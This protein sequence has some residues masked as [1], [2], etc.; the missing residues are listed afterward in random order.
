M[1]SKYETTMQEMLEAMDRCACSLVADLPPA[2][3]AQWAALVRSA[4]AEKEAEI[5]SLYKQIEQLEG[6]LY[7]DGYGGRGVSLF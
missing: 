4:Q 6:Q 2:R 3:V 1:V 5:K 7:P